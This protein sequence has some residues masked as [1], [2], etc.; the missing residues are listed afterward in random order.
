[1][2]EMEKYTGKG[3]TST[4]VHVWKKSAMWHILICSVLTP[5]EGK[6]FLSEDGGFGSSEKK[7]V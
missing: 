3:D 4:M 7:D 5:S 1:M 6:L 2:Y